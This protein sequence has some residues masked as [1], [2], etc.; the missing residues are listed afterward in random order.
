MLRRPAGS[1]PARVEAKQGVTDVHQMFDTRGA[2]KYV[3]STKSTLEKL[4]VFGGSP[5]YIKL[6]RKVI[7]RREDLDT[8][9]NTKRRSNTS[10]R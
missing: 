9:I 7:Y 4:R 10:E 5:I 6:G 3:G 8:W 2:A 1:S